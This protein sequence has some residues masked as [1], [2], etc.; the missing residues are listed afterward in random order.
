[1]L[2]IGNPQP[3]V[4]SN[5]QQELIH[6][7]VLTLVHHLEVLHSCLME[8]QQAQPEASCK[9]T[10]R[11]VDL[12][13]HYLHEHRSEQGDGTFKKPTLNAC[14]LHVNDKGDHQGKP[15]DVESVKGKFRS[16]HFSFSCTDLV[17]ILSI[18]KR[19]PFGDQEMD[20]QVRSPL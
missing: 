20:T 9:W 17:L 2:A 7:Q 6:Q 5:S 14:A 13:V 15:K 19:N 8:G 16:V 3:Y 1:M 10:E 18:D 4:A 11:D 12:M